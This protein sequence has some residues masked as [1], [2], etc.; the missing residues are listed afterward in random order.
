MQLGSKP[1]AR[2]N[3]QS[4]ATNVAEYLEE[5]PED[6]RK[7]LS[8]LRALI[9]KT[10]PDTIETMQYG[11]ASY[12]MGAPLFALASQK[13]H[14][15]LYVCDT[16]AVNAHREGLGNLNCGKGCIRFKRLGDLPLDVVS[17]ILK[18]AF[19]R[20]K[21]GRSAAQKAAGGK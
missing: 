9:R 6:R 4:K 17:D 20:R 1:P 18:E 14:M 11:M 12:T 13:Q 21:K 5:L 3:M 16:D 8:E 2:T 19:Q 15:A 10:A 7:A